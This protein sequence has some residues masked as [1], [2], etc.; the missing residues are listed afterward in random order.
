M[1]LPFSPDSFNPEAMAE[2]TET[3]LKRLFSSTSCK[4]QARPL[5]A[6]FISKLFTIRRHQVSNRDMNLEREAR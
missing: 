2:A 5:A 1:Q 6:L 4:G 3:V